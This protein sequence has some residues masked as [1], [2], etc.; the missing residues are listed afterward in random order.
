MG[1]HEILAYFGLMVLAFLISGYGTIIGAAGGFLYVPLLLLLYPHG[2]HGTLAGIALAVNFV[3]SSSGTVA[4]ARQK[5][6]D[7]KSAL[8]LGAATIPA[9]ILGVKA[10]YSVPRTA[11]EAIFGVFLLALA[12]FLL[13]RPKSDTAPRGKKRLPTAGS[14][15]RAFHLDGITF[16]FHYNRIFGLAVF[17]IL[18]F[19]AS[20]L[21][22]GGGS[23]MMPSLAYLLNFPVFIAAGTSIFI[24]AIITFTATLVHIFTGSMHQGLH[25]IV[26]MAIGALLGGQVGARLSKR[27]K[28]PW[29]IRG[30]ALAIAVAAIRMLMAA[31]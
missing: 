17:F 11:F 29:V 21:G 8:V 25:R 9:S 31:F 24:V 12:V 2:H 4:Y 28:G 3:T 16:E 27:I 5:R 6:I 20:F 23:L 13:L 26:A 14:V 22:I 1:P 10:T 30:L 18:G 7:Y 19:V 15:N